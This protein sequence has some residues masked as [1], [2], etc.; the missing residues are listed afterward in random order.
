MATPAQSSASARG[1]RLRGRLFSA[2]TIVGD[3]LL[4]HLYWLAVSAAIVTVLP[5]S[6]ALQRAIHD[7]LVERRSDTARVFFS[8]FGGSW[9][10]YWVP[11]LVAPI[12]AVMYVFS[13]LFWA[14]ANGWG[15]TAALALLL[16][17]GGFAFCAYL[18]TL[19]AAPTLPDGAGVRQ[20]ARR[21]WAVL[22]RRPLAAAGCLV[23]MITWLLLLSR[24]PTLALVGLGLVP[25]LLALWLAKAPGAAGRT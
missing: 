21:G 11:G 1:A 8:R 5:A 10:T 25:A 2:T 9:R 24:I 22:A 6:V 23:V 7:V 15:R 19:A 12:L 20:T 3:L 14:S 13:L 18:A 16:P 4:L 17:L